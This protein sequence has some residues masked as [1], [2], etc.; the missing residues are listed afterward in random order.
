[1]RIVF[2]NPRRLSCR[3]KVVKVFALF[4]TLGAGPARRAPLRP[5][6]VALQT[7]GSL[8]SL[9]GRSFRSFRT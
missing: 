5:G 6:A 9:R 8:Q 4:G 3:T 1:M 7:V 2:L